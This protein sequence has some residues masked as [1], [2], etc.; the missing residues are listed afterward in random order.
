MNGR[1]KTLV[2]AVVL[3]VV[4]SVLSGPIFSKPA[5]SEEVLR[6]VAAF[7][8]SV[9]YVKSFLRYVDKLNAAGAG[10]VRIQFLGGPE[11]IPQTEQAGAVSRGVIEMQYGPVSHYTGLV[12]EG[13]ALVGSRKS[14]AE[15]RASG[16]MALLAQIYRDKL[17]VHLLGHFDSGIGFHI[18]LKDAPRR[19]ADG[20]IDMEGLKLRSQPIYREFFES[21]GAIAVSVP[22]GETYTALERGMV[23]GTGWPLIG[24]TD[25]SWDRFLKYR[26]DPPFFQTD[27][28]VIINAAIWDGLPG[29][30][31][32]ILRETARAHEIESY[33]YFQAQLPIMDQKVRAGGMQVIELTGETAEHYLA[34]A[35]E[36][37][38]SRLEK[39]DPTHAEELRAKFY[40]D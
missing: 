38:W 14:L 1:R 17:K 9:D 39:R 18:Y 28:V 22:S 30:A 32:R 25:L 11:V 21:L 8:V 12:P 19:T 6:A 13:D 10:V 5:S 20:G 36:V 37:P 29:E 40:S 23:D 4:G 15:A 3:A 33:N 26:V 27:L 31:R 35:Y 2:L 34:R 16:G 24:I 7:P